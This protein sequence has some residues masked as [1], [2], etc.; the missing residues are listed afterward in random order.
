MRVL[1]ST[2]KTIGILSAVGAFSLLA[3]SM[4]QAEGTFDAQ[5]TVALPSELL[6]YHNI[7]P[8]IKMAAAYG[9]RS[10]GS[11]GSF[12]QFPP[13]FETPAHIHSGAY[14]GVV[15]KGVMTNPFKG[16]ANSPSLE[17][18]SYWYVPAG[19]EHTTACISDVPCEF[20]FY[21]DGAFDFTPVE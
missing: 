11:H 14:H 16:E 7:N 13:N 20:Y 8:A 12:G 21:A 19:S 6:E 18:G 1:P 10:K 4:A 15:I 3:G 9:D 17:P 2:I 5:E